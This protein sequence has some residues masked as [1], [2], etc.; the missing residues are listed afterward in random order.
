[1]DSKSKAPNRAMCGPLF[2][3]LTLNKVLKKCGEDEPIRWSRAYLDDVTAGGKEQKVLRFF[4]QVV[5]N[6]LSI[7]LKVNLRKC[8]LSG[9]KVQD[10][11]PSGIPAAPWV[12]DVKILGTPVGS[13]AFVKAEVD[14]VS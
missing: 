12:E 1:M 10:P 8:R 4:D 14:Q 3:S 13:D 6:M 9:P 2:F 7:G 11:H 5:E